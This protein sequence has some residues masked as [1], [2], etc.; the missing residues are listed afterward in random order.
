MELDGNLERN[1]SPRQKTHDP[2]LFHQFHTLPA[3]QA[4]LLLE[5]KVQPELP[6]TLQEVAG[7]PRGIP[8]EYTPF[9]CPASASAALF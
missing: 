4:S 1:T 7:G 9:L 6:C 2:V 5:P 3:L 8:R